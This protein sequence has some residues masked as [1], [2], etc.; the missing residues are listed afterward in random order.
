MEKIC[1]I[2]KLLQF[3][4]KSV[5]FHFY[6]NKVYTDFEAMMDKKKYHNCKVDAYNNA[7]VFSSNN[8]ISICFNPIQARG[9]PKRP[10]LEEIP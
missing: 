10:P 4:L 7:C 1:F 5:C 9:G 8:L 2:K 6:F 3:N